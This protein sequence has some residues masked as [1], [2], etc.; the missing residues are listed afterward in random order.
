VKLTESC[1]CGAAITIEA[2]D[3]I[4]WEV[5][6][7]WRT[8]HMHQ[9]TRPLTVA[10]RAERDRIRSTFPQDWP[11]PYQPWVWGTTPE[12]AAAEPWPELI[13]NHDDARLDPTIVRRCVIGNR[14]DWDPY[15]PSEVPDSMR[16]GL[17]ADYIAGINSARQVENRVPGDLRRIARDLAIAEGWVTV[18]DGDD[19]LVADV[20]LRGLRQFLTAIV[21][22]RL[23]P[24]INVTG[25]ERLNV[26]VTKGDTDPD[27]TWCSVQWVLATG[28]AP[29]CT[30]SIIT[31]QNANPYTLDVSGL[32]A[33][34]RD[35]MPT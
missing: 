9:A 3:G 15:G 27:T 5:L 2:A 22:A 32:T 1:S 25:V 4:P 16:L 20:P 18:A 34:I 33:W 30:R 23:V 24:R 7:M 13:V 12:D 11:D 28:E 17:V 10:E 14:C 26:Y 31:G 6:S 21:E 8:S 29:S 19:R 35:G